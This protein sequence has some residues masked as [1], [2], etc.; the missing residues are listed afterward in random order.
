MTLFPITNDAYHEFADGM[1]VT[2]R[3]FSDLIITHRRFPRRAPRVEEHYRNT[4]TLAGVDETLWL[5][6]SPLSVAEINSESA[7]STNTVQGKGQVIV[8]VGTVEPRKRQ[9]HVLEAITSLQE[10]GVISQ[11]IETHVF[12][13]LHPA[14]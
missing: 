13:S 1:C 14:V 6:K 7:R 5:P 10:S 3:S 8:L 11:M 2:P 9:V 12:G 4:F